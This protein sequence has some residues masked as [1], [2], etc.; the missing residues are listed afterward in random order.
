MTTQ[1]YINK[2]IALVQEIS[3]F[4]EKYQIEIRNVAPLWLRDI[5]LSQFIELCDKFNHDSIK[6]E[7]WPSTWLKV[8]DINIMLWGI[9]KIPSQPV[10]P[11]P[12]TLD[13][14]RT[15]TYI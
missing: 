7:E 9:D 1:E 12:S 11:T 10:P 15:F 14:L 4:N 13:Y 5:P 2:I 3:D 8:K 6:I